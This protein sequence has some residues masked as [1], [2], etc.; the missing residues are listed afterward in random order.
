MATKQ[1]LDK[2]GLS[3]LWEKICWQDQDLLDKITANSNRIDEIAQQQGKIWVESATTMAWDSE[4]TLVAEQGIIY[5]YTD[6]RT[7]LNQTAPRVKIG[8]GE[9]LLKDLQFIDE[10]INTAIRNLET[11]IDDKVGCRMDETTLQFYKD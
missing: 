6:A 10:D 3:R 7:V 5:V 4:P 11:R 1:Y 2:T 9:T 8:D